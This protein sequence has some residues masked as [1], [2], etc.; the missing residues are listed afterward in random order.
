MADARAAIEAQRAHIKERQEAERLRLIDP[1]QQLR[2]AKLRLHQISQS[3]EQKF[4]AILREKKY[5]L[6]SLT[7]ELQALSPYYFTLLS[8]FNFDRASTAASPVRVMHI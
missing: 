3:L 1:R 7:G 8:R 4:Q 2:E 5:S 6:Q